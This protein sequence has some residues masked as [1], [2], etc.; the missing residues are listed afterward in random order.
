[1][2]R[3]ARGDNLMKNIPNGVAICLSGQSNIQHA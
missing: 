2:R 1:M 3:V